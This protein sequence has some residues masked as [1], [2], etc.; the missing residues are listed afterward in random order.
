MRR[1]LTKNSIIRNTVVMNWFLV[2]FFGHSLVAKSF[3]IKTIQKFAQNK[4]CIKFAL[5]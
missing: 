5:A 2:G 1:A 3:L 4:I